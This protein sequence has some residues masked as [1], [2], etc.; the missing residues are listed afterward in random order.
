MIASARSAYIVKRLEQSGIIDYKNISKELD[1]SEATVRRDFEKLERAGQLRRVQ[2][3]AVRS[4]TILVGELSV[5]AKEGLHAEEKRRV[6]KKAA[7]EV[8]DGENIFL[9]CG[10]SIAPIAG[11]LM[12]RKVHIVTNNHLVLSYAYQNSAA[13]IFFLGGQF[14]PADQ[15]CTGPL[16][17]RVLSGFLFDR[18]FIGCMGLDIARNEV[19]VT[20]MESLAI[21]QLAMKNA[22]SSSLLTDTSKEG[23]HGPFRLAGCQDFDRVYVND[24]GTRRNYPK[25]FIVV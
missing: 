18:A 10:T 16:T 25:N 12:H 3:G 1:V 8:Q 11:E 23:A 2:G 14:C 7:E 4:D 17:L 22:K 6:A 20:E 13:E 9:D 5:T 21:K 15:L 19:Y 24:G